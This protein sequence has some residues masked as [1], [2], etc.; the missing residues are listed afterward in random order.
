MDFTETPYAEDFSYELSIMIEK[1]LALGLSKGI[2]EEIV[3]M[4]IED[5]FDCE[6]DEDEE[7]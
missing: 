5:M 4:A 7:I 6:D 2:A 3:H 1:Y